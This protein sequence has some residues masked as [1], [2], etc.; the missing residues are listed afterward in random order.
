VN[1]EL[2]SQ[3]EVYVHRIG[4]T[5]RAGKTGLAV[6]LCSEREREALRAIEEFSGARLESVTRTS[7]DRRERPRATADTPAAELAKMDTLRISGCRKE[8]LRPGDILGALTGDAGGLK[9]EDIGKIEIHDHFSYVAVN[10]AASRAAQQSLSAG[11]IKGQRFR[12]A[13]VE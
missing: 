7:T 10:K 8:K 3:P 11:R 6:S 4:R 2:P 1:F 13:I 9:A 12:V 5:G